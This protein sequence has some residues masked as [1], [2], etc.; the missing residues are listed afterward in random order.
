MPADSDDI[1]ALIGAYVPQGLLLPRTTEE[2]AASIGDY[3]VVV[4]G[5][6]RVEACAALVEYSPSLG[7]VASVAVAPGAQGKGLGGLAVRSIET[8]ARQRGIRELFALSLAERFF[9]SLDYEP[10]RVESFPEKVARYAAL[11]RRGVRVIPKACFR[12]VIA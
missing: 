6:G 9:E 1:H 7:E 11:D 12:K 8:L 5:N 2:V 10:A 4:D 3:V